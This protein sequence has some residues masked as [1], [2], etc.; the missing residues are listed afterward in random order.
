MESGFKRWFLV[1]GVRL[2]E[3]DLKNDF[4]YE[5]NVRIDYFNLDR[6]VIEVKTIDDPLIGDLKYL[7]L[8]KVVSKLKIKKVND[9]LEIALKE[10]LTIYTRA[11]SGNSYYEAVYAFTVKEC[12]LNTPPFLLKL[13]SRQVNEILERGEI[14]AHTFCG[15]LYV[16]DSEVARLR[17]IY[18][19][20]DVFKL[21]VIWTSGHRND[22]KPIL[23][24]KDHLFVFVNDLY[25]YL[26]RNKVDS[27]PKKLHGHTVKANKRAAII[28]AMYYEYEK[29]NKNRCKNIR[30]CVDFMID[31]IK[32]NFNKE[33][34]TYF[35]LDFKSFEGVDL[36]ELSDYLKNDYVIGVLYGKYGSKSDN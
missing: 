31:D 23:I 3:E 18:F 2:E 30:V 12:Y 14:S 1:S 24:T 5:T 20:R 10:N 36:N 4:D 13:D 27:L 21:D 8:E 29:H 7:S 25:D 17:P 26:N 22:L 11:P 32:K 15:G 6:D 16:T 33:K 19:R 35:N 9:F 34:K 28:E